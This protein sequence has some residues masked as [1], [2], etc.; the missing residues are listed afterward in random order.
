MSHDQ[1]T[2]TA[3]AETVAYYVE[4]EMKDLAERNA[5][6]AEVDRLRA[7]VN[8]I[9]PEAGGFDPATDEDEIERIALRW[10]DRFH[11]LKELARQ[12]GV[13]VDEI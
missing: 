6:M 9:V 11:R 10:C 7:I 8:T 4:R 13:N 5:L 2:T 1:T 12:A 3:S